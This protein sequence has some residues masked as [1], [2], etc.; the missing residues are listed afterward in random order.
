LDGIRQNPNDIAMIRPDLAGLVRP[1]APDGYTL[2]PF[3]TGEEA[4]WADLLA[5]TFPEMPEPQS[6]PRKEFLRA[7]IWQPGRIFFACKDNVPVACATAW[8]HA[9]IWGP[10]SGIVH[11][12]AT[13]PD[14]RGR[15]LARAVVLAAMNWMRTTGYESAILVT[16]IQRLPAIRLY[17]GLGFR[18]HLAAFP[19]MA[20][21]WAKVEA[22][23]RL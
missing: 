16:Q 6:I 19:E 4:A 9:H 10:K 5:A 22:D 1:Q 17:L 3:H 11:W 8:E 23:L 21:R 2:R 7:S 15:G 12:V 18:P 13:H 20:E 14:H